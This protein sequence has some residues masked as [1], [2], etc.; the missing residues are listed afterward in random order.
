[1]LAPDVVLHLDRDADDAGR[2]GLLGLGLHPGQRQLAGLV[3]AL[4]ELRHLLILARLAQ[5]LH[6]ALVGDVVDAGA[7]HERHRDRSRGQQPEEVLCRQIRGERPAIG[8]AVRALAG[9]VPDGGAGC[10]EL[11]A[12]LAPGVHLHPELHADDAVRAEVIG[13]G[14]HARHRELARV[15][16]GLGEDL[17]LLILAPPADLEADVVDRR[18]DDEAERLEASLAEQDVLRHR[19][20]RSEYAGRAGTRCL[21]EPAVGSLRF[22]GARLVLRTGKQRHEASPVCGIAPL[23]AYC[24][25]RG[26]AL[27]SRGACRAGLAVAD[28]AAGAARFCCPP[29]AAAVS[30][31]ARS[32][33]VT[34]SS[35]RCAVAAAYN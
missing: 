14:L 34:S 27:R 21:R 19:Q 15:V 16:H 12:A 32:R 3:D 23:S 6:D 26:R 25:C 33:T 10:D 20:V 4:G 17:E 7:E 31:S 29:D 2:A 5:R 24:R 35:G 30:P 1:M 18:P 22:P 13:L 9:Q 11:Q 8:S 28:R